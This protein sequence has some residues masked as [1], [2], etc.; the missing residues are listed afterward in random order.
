VSLELSSARCCALRRYWER[1]CSARSRAGNQTLNVV[2]LNVTG[3]S[4]GTCRTGQRRPIEN[5]Y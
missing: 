3:P 1:I 5:R 2:T 4:P